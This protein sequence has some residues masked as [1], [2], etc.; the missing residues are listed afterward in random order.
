M[1]LPQFVRIM[2]FNSSSS[3]LRSFTLPCSSSINDVKLFDLTSNLMVFSEYS[4]FVARLKYFV[5][6]S[7]ARSSM[8]FT[9]ACNGVRRNV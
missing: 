1:R 5:P 6:A 2:R 4:D 3:I 7:V 9:P 8:V